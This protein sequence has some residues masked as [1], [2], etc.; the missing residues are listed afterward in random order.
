[1]AGDNQHFEKIFQ[2][3]LDMIQYERVGVETALEQYP[4]LADQLRPELETA[5]WFLERSQEFEPRPEFVSDSRERLVEQIRLE[6]M[7]EQEVELEEEPA[8]QPSLDFLTWLTGLFKPENFSLRQAVLTTLVAILVIGSILVA[9]VSQ[10]SLPGDPLYSVKTGLEKAALVVTPSASGAARLHVRYAER[11]LAEIQTLAREGRYQYIAPTV[12]DFQVQVDQAIQAMNGLAGQDL[13]EAKQ[14]A[15][16]LQQVLTDQAPAITHLSRSAPQD[17]KQELER[18]LDV[19]KTG[20][21][22]ASDVLSKSGAISILPPT[23]TSPRP[24]AISGG[25]SSGRNI[26]RPTPTPTSSSGGAQPTSYIVST[27]LQPAV[28]TPTRTPRPL[29]PTPT[30]APSRQPPETP[31]PTATPT[32]E[33]TDEPEPTVAP[34]ATDT[35]TPTLTLTWTP[36]ATNTAIPTSTSTPTP[37]LTATATITPTNTVAPTTT[38]VPVSTKVTPTPTATIATPTPTPTATRTPLPT[39]TRTPTPIPTNTPTPTNTAV[40]KFGKL[41]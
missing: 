19:S 28:S 29:E 4:E 26:S 12:A 10:S 8:Q 9:G 34:P 30:L 7:L 2:I 33:A 36:T 38:I 25:G 14:L 17:S 23:A 40:I 15:Q 21:T 13:S 24:G 11:R 41:Y 22:A 37:T 3:C 1:M 35:S 39:T 20:L 16:N 6:S 32:P 18:V 27:P 31:R 5:S